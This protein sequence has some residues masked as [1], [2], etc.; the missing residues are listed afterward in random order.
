LDWL[1]ALNGIQWQSEGLYR[2]HK[3]ISGLES[4][5]LEKCIDGFEVYFCGRCLLIFTSP[6]RQGNAVTRKKYISNIVI[7]VE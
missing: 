2:F 6:N 7:E 3:V 1:K 4:P 5:P